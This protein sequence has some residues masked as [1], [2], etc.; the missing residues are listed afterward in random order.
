MLSKVSHIVANARLT[1]MSEI[2]D[3]KVS[4]GLEE[5]MVV[6]TAT[7]MRRVARH[8]G[9]RQRFPIAYARESR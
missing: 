8:H 5:L 1:G 3:K 6:M 9:C 4:N 2:T 7:A